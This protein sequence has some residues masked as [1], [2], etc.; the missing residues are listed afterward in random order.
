MAARGFSALRSAVSGAFAA[1]PGVSDIRLPP[2]LDERRL[3][4]STATHSSSPD[5]TLK[6]AP[7]ADLPE[8]DALDSLSR[9]ELQAL[10]AKVSRRLRST[11][12]KLASARQLLSS[13]L[14]HLQGIDLAV[15]SLTGISLADFFR[16]DEDA[17]AQTASPGGTSSAPGL[18]ASRVVGR[19]LPHPALALASGTSTPPAVRGAALLSSPAVGPA[20]PA[21]RGAAAATSPLRALLL[22]GSP[23]DLIAYSAA[24]SLHWAQAQAQTAAVSRRSAA[25]APAPVPATGGASLDAAIA[26]STA[27]AAAA[28]AA[29][30]TSARAQAARL[31]SDLAAA[32]RQLAASREETAGLEVGG[33]R[34][35]ASLRPMSPR[36]PPPP[37]PPSPPFSLPAAE[38]VQ[39][40]GRVGGGSTCH[41]VRRRRGSRSRR[42]LR[43]APGRRG[44]TTRR[45]AEERGRPRP[46]GN[47][48]ADPPGFHCCGAA[49]ARGRTGRGS[50][51]AA[52]GC[53]GA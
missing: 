27:A 6:T 30:L 47:G 9:P 20:S 53:R 13:L 35:T 15:C 33:L 25:A 31:A 38:A 48:G 49:G 11:E 42:S 40:S 3:A 28:T 1:S 22:G 24:L 52:G 39:G 29:A 23:L 8:P 21:A 16:F 50:R 17:R 51:G 10:C 44:G 12:G 37:S 45:T 41:R 34:T 5:S 18:A 46:G 43:G 32:Q 36:H 14:Q 2:P 4:Q 26:G 7:D 19:G